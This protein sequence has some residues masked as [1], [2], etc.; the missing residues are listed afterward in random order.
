MI[1]LSHASPLEYLATLINQLDS[2]ESLKVHEPLLDKSI[3]L[4]RELSGH[5]A[6][7]E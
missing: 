5:L 7:R 2:Y 4:V 1:S 3:G 6:G